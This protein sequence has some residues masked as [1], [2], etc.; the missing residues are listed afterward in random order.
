MGIRVLHASMGKKLL[1]GGDYCL[2]LAWVDVRHIGCLAG[3]EE[4]R[5]DCWGLVVGG[6]EKQFCMS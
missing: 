3:C 1:H 4:Y 2:L 6:G 5:L